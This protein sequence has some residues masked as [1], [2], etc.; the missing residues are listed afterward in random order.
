MEEKRSN[1]VEEVNKRLFR[2]VFASI[3]VQLDKH[4]QRALVADNVTFVLKMD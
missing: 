1:I 3:S 4:C 2:A